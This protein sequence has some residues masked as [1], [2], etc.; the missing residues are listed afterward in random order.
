MFDKKI[1]AYLG[2]TPNFE[3][4]VKLKDD[5]DG[6]VYIKEWNITSEKAKPTDEE[7]NALSSQAET[8]V[9]NNMAVANR[10]AEYGSTAEQ[11]EY[12]TENGLEAWQSKVQEIKT[13]YP[14]ENS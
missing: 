8:L 2:R 11:I 5:G 13:K 3:T 7:L 9:K 6:V 1:I 4:E 10:K 14:K 12:I